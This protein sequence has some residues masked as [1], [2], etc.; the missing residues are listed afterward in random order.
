MWN[1]NVL[2]QA[3]KFFLHWC[4]S[5]SWSGAGLPLCGI[6]SRIYHM[7]DTVVSLQVMQ[8]MHKITWPG[9]NLAQSSYS[10]SHMLAHWQHVFVNPKKSL[11]VWSL[12]VSLG[13]SCQEALL[14]QN[15]QSGRSSNYTCGDILKRYYIY[16]YRNTQDQKQKTG[17]SFLLNHVPL[18][19]HLSF[20]VRHSCESEKGRYSPEPA[21]MVWQLEGE[22]DFNLPS[23]L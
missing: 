17:S 7:G 22:P 8:F 16:S 4:R 6:R 14:A 20:I 5:L 10:P 19:D 3:P 12:C 21:R 1:H 9:W 2:T 23:F 18:Q 15:S 13:W 11:Y